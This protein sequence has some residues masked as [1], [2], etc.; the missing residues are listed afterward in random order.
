MDA[1]EVA[2]VAAKW[3]TQ[4]VNVKDVWYAQKTDGTLLRYNG[5]GTPPEVA[6]AIR[7]RTD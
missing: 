2:A 7:G 6:E 5:E 1:S 3:G 4:Y